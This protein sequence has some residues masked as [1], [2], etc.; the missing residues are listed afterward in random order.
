MHSFILEPSSYSACR[1]ECCFYLAMLEE[2]LRGPGGEGNGTEL[3][4]KPGL[5][6]QPHPALNSRFSIDRAVS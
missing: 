1:E 2:S 6:R 5:G 3:A 4:N